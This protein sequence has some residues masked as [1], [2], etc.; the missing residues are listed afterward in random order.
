MGLLLPYYFDDDTL[1]TLPIKLAVEDTLPGT[2]IEFAIGNGN[3]DLVVEQEVFEMGIT[4]IFARLV[5]VIVWIFGRQF[6]HPLHDIAVEAGFLV[7]DDDRGSDVHGGDKGETIPDATLADDALYVIGDRNDFFA[8]F[9][10][11]GQVDGVGFH[12]YTPPRKALETDWTTGN[13]RSI[14]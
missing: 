12:M 3:D 13:V 8:F 6:L 2:S 10:V 9:G 7:V 1:G 11:K 5:M 14:S 4:I